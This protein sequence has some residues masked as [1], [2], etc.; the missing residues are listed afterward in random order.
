MTAAPRLLGSDAAIAYWERRHAERDELAAGGDIG[1]GVEGNRSF[2][3]V[4]TGA[5]LTLLAR[6]ALG[7]RNAP[8][9]ILDAG[10]GQGIFARSLAECGYDVI[11]VDAS[12]TS[13]DI[14][15]S[16][17]GGVRYHVGALDQYWDDELFDVVIAI[18]VLFHLTDDATFVGSVERLAAHVVHGGALIITDR[19]ETA[20]TILG[21]YIVH[22]P[23]AEYETLL[24]PRGF[25]H[26]D[27]RPYDF[28]RNPIGFH[29]FRKAVSR[30]DR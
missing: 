5:L 10:C 26:V 1:L 29:E 14:A 27:F 20:R 4:R 12:P 15:R 3:A 23:R 22:R 19:D 8:L 16:A 18:D 6:I 24:A 30:A 7:E 2:Y 9:R 13:I 25:E 21:D 17:G 28:P 11:G